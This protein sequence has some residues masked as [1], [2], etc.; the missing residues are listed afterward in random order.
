MRRRPERESQL[1]DFWLSKDPKS[2]EVWCVT[3]YD[4]PARQTRRSSTG[5]RDLE[6]ARI[7]LAKWVLLETDV[8]DERPDDV[9]LELVFDRYYEKHAKN[10]ASA[11]RARIALAKWK[12]WWAGKTIADLTLENQEKFLQHLMGEPVKRGS[13][14]TK[15]SAGTVARDWGVGRSAILWA[16]KNH[17]IKS[18]PYVKLVTGGG[19]R[20]RVFTIE[21]AGKFFNAA[22]KREHTWRYALL[23]FGFSPRPGTVLRITTKPEQ[24]DL[25]H[26]RLNLLPPGEQQIPRKRKPILPIPVTLRP[27]LRRWMQPEALVYKA[28]RKGRSQVRLSHL[29]TWHGK[30]LK[31]SRATFDLI[32]HEAGLDDPTLTPYVI[33][34][35]IATWMAELDVPDRQREIWLG[36]RAPGSATT[37]RYTH[38][39]PSYLK[40]AAAAVD[41]FFEALAPLLERPVRIGIVQSEVTRG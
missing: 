36:H 4:K 34:H 22:A 23:S 3:W 37:A 10:L 18:H 1:G 14:A 6:K 39:K 16:F 13:R 24:V 25:A 32:K 21:E 30:R 8:K 19:T 41:S 20:E 40:D 28:T 7:T 38:L 29:I 35:T 26:N 15:R 31:K 12:A 17:Q 2:P 11:E 33:R 9:P 5:E 27:W